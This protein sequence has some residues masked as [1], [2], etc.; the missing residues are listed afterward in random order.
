ML[1]YDVSPSTFLKYYQMSKLTS[2]ECMKRAPYISTNNEYVSSRYL[3][4][5]IRSD[6]RKTL[7]LHKEAHSVAGMV[8]S[9]GC[10]HIGWMNCPVAGRDNMKEKRANLL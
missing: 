3:Q 4:S 6:A 10:M 9:L 1:G 5:M 2:Y 7:G 8:G